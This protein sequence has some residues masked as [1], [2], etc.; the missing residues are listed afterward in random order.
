MINEIKIDKLAEENQNKARIIKEATG[1][2]FIVIIIGEINCFIIKHL[3]ESAAHILPVSSAN[4]NPVMIL[5]K[6]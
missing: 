4:K 1:I 6:E 3:A 5:I 2:V